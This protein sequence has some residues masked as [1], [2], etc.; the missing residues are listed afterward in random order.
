MGWTVIADVVDESSEAYRTGY[1]FGTYVLVP[2]LVLAIVYF[3]VW[4]P[5]WVHRF[6]RHLDTGDRRRAYLQLQRY[7][8]PLRA[9]SDRKANQPRVLARV[10]GL[11]LLDDLDALRA[12]LDR[13]TGGTAFRVNVEMFG[14]LA[15]ATARS[16][17]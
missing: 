13:H 16:A 17:D 8:K 1:F 6:L 2:A 12:E 3:Y 10:L 14:L 9:K 5:R 15:L 7:G 11:W 4:V